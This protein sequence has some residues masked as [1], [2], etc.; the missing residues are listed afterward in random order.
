[1]VEA[2]A[3]SVCTLEN[4]M[5]RASVLLG[6]MWL[7]PLLA[8]CF[9][10]ESLHQSSSRDLKILLRDYHASIISGHSEA[11][12]FT[13]EPL[14]DDSFA[15]AVPYINAYRPT[16]LYLDGSRL[17]EPSLSQFVQL[18]SVRYLDLGRCGVNIEKLVAL[19]AM[20]RLEGL[21]VDNSAKYKQLITL[22]KPQIGVGGSKY[23]GDNRQ[24]HRAS[25]F[26]AM[27]VA[28]GEFAHDVGQFIRGFTMPP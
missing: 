21:W 22:M 6:V 27:R 28:V 12:F 1:M 14:D 19:K 11:I 18:D 17:T 8:G 9:A 4:H 2:I 13:D 23:S 20:P 3:A 7:P 24:S 5:S 25:M 10:A 15:G 16:E 26:A